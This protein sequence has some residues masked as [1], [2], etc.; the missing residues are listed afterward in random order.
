LGKRLPDKVATRLRLRFGAASR[1]GASEAGAAPWLRSS[2]GVLFE[3][4]LE[5]SA[6]LARMYNNEK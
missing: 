5:F 1:D 4:S 3:F 6:T 2:A